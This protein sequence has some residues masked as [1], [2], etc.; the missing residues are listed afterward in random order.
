[1]APRDRLVT[2]GDFSEPFST[3]NVSFQ[4]KKTFENW[5]N[6]QSD[7]FQSTPTPLDFLKNFASGK[8]FS[9]GDETGSFSMAPSGAFNLSSPKGWA[10]TGNPS[11][12]SLG[13]SFPT[14]VGGNKGTI[15]LEGGWDPENSYGK[16]NFEFGKKAT[17]L[18]DYSSLAR[19]AVDNMV[20]PP[21]VLPNQQPYS[22]DS[23]EKSEGRKLYEQMVQQLESPTEALRRY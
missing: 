20:A 1:M 21:G 11:T 23:N 8:G 18:G 17:R 19:S 6:T 7:S 9:I 16:I 10:V 15:G 5:V 3:P 14:S 4:P 2:K 13:V 12:K 22:F